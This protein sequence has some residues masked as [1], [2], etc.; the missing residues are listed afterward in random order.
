M[1]PVMLADAPDPRTCTASSHWWY[2]APN[3]IMGELSQEQIFLPY[4]PKW[5][6]EH[7]WSSQAGVTQSYS[8]IDQLVSSEIE[9]FCFTLEMTV[10]SFLTVLLCKALHS[11]ASCSKPCSQAMLAFLSKQSLENTVK[12]A[13]LYY[14][15]NVAL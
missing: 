3:E 4:P 9:R 2:Q 8:A 12:S 5:T 15:P 14:A 13:Q 10:C 1:G 7:L 6:I 11:K